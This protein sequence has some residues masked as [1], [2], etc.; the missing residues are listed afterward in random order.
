MS[1]IV[2][3]RMGIQGTEVPVISDSILKIPEELH[4]KVN[5]IQT[6]ATE[7]NN[8]RLELGRLMQVVNHLTYVCNTTEKNLSKTKA[9]VI[10]S[11]GLGDGNWAIFFE[12]MSVGRVSKVSPSSPTVV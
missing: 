4:G 5:S 3:S 8:N 11:M 9:E 2:H 10:K 1:T 7:L 6:L 12:T